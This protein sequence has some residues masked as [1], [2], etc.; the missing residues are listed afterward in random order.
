MPVERRWDANTTMAVC[1]T[2]PEVVYGE[3]DPPEEDEPDLPPPVLQPPAVASGSDGIP[4]PE[5]Q[6]WYVDRE[7]RGKIPHMPQTKKP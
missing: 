5:F 4:R 6:K 7:M 1:W 2:V 3:R